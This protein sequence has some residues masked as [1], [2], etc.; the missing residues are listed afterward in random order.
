MGIFTYIRKIC[1]YDFSGLFIVL[2]I[3][4]K[5]CC[6]IWVYVFSKDKFTFFHVKQEKFALQCT[7]FCCWGL[8]MGIS[9][10]ILEICIYDFSP[11]FIVLLIP[12]KRCCYIWVYVFSKDKFTF[13]HVKQEKF[14]LQCTK[15][16]C[17]GLK[18]GIFTYI[19]KICIYNFS[20]LFIVLLIPFKRCC[21]IWVYVF[22]KDKFT[23][24]HVK[25]EKFALQCT[26]FCCWGLKMGIFT[27]IRK[28]CIYDFS[29]LFIVLLIPFKRMLLYMGLCFF[30]R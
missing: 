8:K 1:I 14:A 29:G 18:M 27:Y 6:Y 28:I 5:R 20:G 21:Y 16:C 23:F 13:F 19:R 11:F 12:F 17:W 26:K 10:Y 24:F 30:K 15:F 22:S 4:F 3:P 9:P 25:Q 7:K 2:I